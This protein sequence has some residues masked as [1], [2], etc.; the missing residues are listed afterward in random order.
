M[1]KRQ[2]TREER[3]LAASLAEASEKELKRAKRSRRSKKSQPTTPELVERPLFMSASLP[4]PPIP[5]LPTLR[6]A[7]ALSAT[8]AKKSLDDFDVNSIQNYHELLAALKA[9]KVQITLGNDIIAEDNILINYDVAINFNGHSIISDESIPAARVLDIRSGEVTLTGK[10][11]IFAMGDRSVALRVFGAIST[12]MPFYTTVTV[13]EGI[14][15]F[16]PTSSAIFVAANL[17]AAYGLNLNFSGEIIAHDGICISSDVRGQR[18]R[19]LPVITLKSGARIIVDETSGAALSAMGYGIWHV[20]AVCLRGAVGIKAK[21]GQIHCSHTQIVSNGPADLATFQIEPNDVANLELSIEGGNYLSEHGYVLSGAAGSLSKLSI[22]DGELQGTLGDYPDDIKRVLDNSA[23]AIND[24]DFAGEVRPLALPKLPV[25][26]MPTAAPASSPAP[27]PEIPMPSPV[28]AVPAA[29]NSQ[30]ILP[31]EPDERAAMRNVLS[32][33]LADLEK[34][35]SA[36]YVSGFSAMRRAINQAKKVLRHEHASLA[37]IRDAASSL[38]AAFDN[39]EEREDFS[40][41][42]EELDELF[43]HGA[44]L[45]EVAG[46]HLKPSKKTRRF[47][48]KTSPVPVSPKPLPA[49][50]VIQPVAPQPV[51][52]PAPVA[53]PTPVFTQVTPAVSTPEVRAAAP[54]PSPAPPIAKVISAPVT[55]PPQPE[56]NLSTLRDVIATIARLD[57]QKY[58]AASYQALLATLTHAKEIIGRDSVQQHEI[59]QISSRLLAQL[60]ELEPAPALRQLSAF[61]SEAIDEM[62][63][64]AHWS[65]GVSSIDEAT[66]FDYANYRPPKSSRFR[67]TISGLVKSITAGAKAGFAT[68]R[69]TRRSAKTA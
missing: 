28:P 19:N 54:V 33:A 38:L 5:P 24:P 27:I 62:A 60:A 32:E 56:P 9:K 10:G 3:E 34:L 69:R 11:K 59:D 18:P 42:D 15:L 25:A 67:S 39:L 2:K 8:L 17:G 20:G 12:E 7:P 49:V 55:P 22:K 44:V 52:P 23:R 43:Y 47:G 53:A 41:S 31:P 29:E 68:Y 46:D 30:P 16:S 61:S 64:A 14:S 21:S 50:P 51:R 6:P 1:R 65:V 36:D 63:P 40:L 13:D 37:D 57:P 26:P 45:E 48:K 4:A 66:P 35:R 58:S